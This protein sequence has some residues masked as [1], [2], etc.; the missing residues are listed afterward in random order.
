MY[1]ATA[2]LVDE[3]VLKNP[4][5]N[6][7]NTECQVRHLITPA[8]RIILSNVCTSIPHEFLAQ[9]LKK[10]NIKSASPITFIRAGI[11]DPEYSHIMSF[12]RQLFISN[13]NNEEIPTLILVH[14]E[15]TDYR[16]YLSGELQAC[17]RYM[18][19]S[20]AYSFSMPEQHISKSNNPT[21]YRKIKYASKSTTT[22]STRA[23]PYLLSAG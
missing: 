18:Q 5:I 2:T 23:E 8:K 15:N 20:W 10:Y 1:L 12:R 19:K 21:T 14:Y 4:C 16:L 3:F 22:T 11:R 9:E 13:S 7:D 6:I 17:Y